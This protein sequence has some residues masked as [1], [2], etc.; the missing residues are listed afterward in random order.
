MAPM[1]HKHL[2]APASRLSALEGFRTVRFN[3][4]RNAA[5]TPPRRH[6]GHAE[7]NNRQK[8]FIR[9][10]PCLCASEVSSSHSSRASDPF[11]LPFIPFI[12]FILFIVLF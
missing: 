6:G 7:E 5:N 8:D 12:P 3:A 2:A 4:S 9:A 11:L 1:A 10:S